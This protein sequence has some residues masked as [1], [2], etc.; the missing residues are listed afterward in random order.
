M[1]HYLVLLTLVTASVA[2]PQA[3]VRT[4]ELPEPAAQI[5]SYQHGLGFKNSAMS[6]V[7]PTGVAPTTD[8]DTNPTNDT[9][10]P[11]SKSKANTKRKS[12]P[13]LSSP[14]LRLA[15]EKAKAARMHLRDARSAMEESVDDSKTERSHMMSNNAEE[16]SVV[17][18]QAL[19]KLPKAYGGILGNKRQL[20]SQRAGNAGFWTGFLSTLGVL[21]FMA[22]IV[23]VAVF[24][25]KWQDDHGNDSGNLYPSLPQRRMS[26]VSSLIYQE[27]RLTSSARYGGGVVRARDRRCS[28]QTLPL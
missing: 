17:R 11:P 7:T 12:R 4:E 26:G 10:A 14:R 21:G 25:A 3:P 5:V 2:L 28:V 23:G 15:L 9:G 13:S 19:P 18:P 16:D 6:T 20:S 1:S 22:T 27:S 8:E 24:G